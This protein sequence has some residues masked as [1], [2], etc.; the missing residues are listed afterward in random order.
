MS[1]NFPSDVTQ[2]KNLIRQAISEPFPPWEQEYLDYHAARFVDTLDLLGPGEGKRLLDVGAFPGHL[3]LAV[4]AVGYQV[5]ALTGPDE[6]ARGLQNFTTRLSNH[7]ISVVRADVEFDP[8]PFPDQSFDVILAAEIIEHLPFN[9]YHMLHESFRVLKPTGRIVLSTPNLTKLDNLLRFAIGRTIHPDIRL[10]FHKTFKSILTGRHI[11]EYTAEE[12]I[13]LLEEQNK[14]MYRFEGTRVSYSL[15][16]DPA[17]SWI[18]AISW[19]LKQLWPPFRATIFIQAIRPDHLDLIEP[20]KI[21]AKGFYEQEEHDAQMGSTGRV[22][23]TPFRWTHSHA[24][25]SL[26]AGETRFQVFFLHLIFLA[27]RYLPPA[28]LGIRVGE[29]S[30]GTVCISPSREYIPLRLALP[31]YLAGKG[32]FNLSFQCSTWRPDEHAQGVD[33]YE[34]SII[35]HRDLGL[36]V[37]WDGFLREECTDH[38]MLMK[39]AKREC[40]RQKLHEGNEGRWSPLLGLYLLQAE[41]KSS[42]PIGPGDWRQLGHGWHQ[43]ERWEQD[44]MRWSSRRSEVYLETGSGS[45]QLRVRVYTGTS[46]LGKEINGSVDIDWASDRL[47]FLPLSKNSFTLPSDCWTDLT[48]DLPPSLA[49]GGLLRVII[50]VSQPRVPSRLSTDSQDGRELGL[51]VFGLV[52]S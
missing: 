52:I 18:G 45:R 33:Y 42:L 8:F 6:S 3:T 2:I 22:L 43:L 40:R 41:M 38:E 49:V 24:E 17:F 25:L 21:E 36:A 32:K 39:V 9:P 7:Q 10:P 15:C 30:L 44:W 5:D 1:T 20:K 23:S 4:Q 47:V 35:D 13:Y 28:F 31:A 34:F 26:P 19:F 14:E 46:A 48:I 37:G 50:M 29:Y 12:L 51:A 27:P 11:R 16:L